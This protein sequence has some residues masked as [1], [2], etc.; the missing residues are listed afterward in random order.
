MSVRPCSWSTAKAC[1]RSTSARVWSLQDSGPSSV[2]PSSVAM[3][4]AF[5]GVDRAPDQ[6]T[7]RY[8]W[9]LTWVIA[10]GLGGSL[11]ISYM[12]YRT[13]ERQWIGRADSSAQRLSAM[14]LGWVEESYS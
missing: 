9:L 13:A 11:T 10:I 14:L 3:L 7:R 1:R 5:S 8:L 4:R 12:L 2:R 6:R